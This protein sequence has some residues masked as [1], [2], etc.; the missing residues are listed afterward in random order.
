MQKGLLVAIA[1]C[2]AALSLAAAGA[3]AAA[4]AANRYVDVQEGYSITLPAQW[5]VIPRTAR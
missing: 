2:A 1:A 4:P 5:Y 3:Q